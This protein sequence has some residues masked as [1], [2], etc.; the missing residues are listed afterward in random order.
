MWPMQIISQ[1]RRN[2]PV[3]RC[4]F[5]LVKPRSSLPSDAAASI[6]GTPPLRRQLLMR[7]GSM[8]KALADTLC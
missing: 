7:R 1:Q 3:V 5:P 8:V 6:G 2:Q 4:S